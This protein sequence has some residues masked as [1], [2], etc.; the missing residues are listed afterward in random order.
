MKKVMQQ[1]RWCVSLFRIYQ[2][3]PSIHFLLLNQAQGSGES[4]RDRVNVGTFDQK[5]KRRAEEHFGGQT[6]LGE[7]VPALA[8][9]VNSILN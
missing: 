1:S 4:G 9:G 2:N 7:K 6:L 3:V 5:S 8:D